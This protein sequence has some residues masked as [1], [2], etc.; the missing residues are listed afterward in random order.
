MRVLLVSTYESG[1]QPL[2]IAVPAAA[3]VDAGHEVKTADLALGPLDP[4]AIDWAEAAAFSVPMHTAMRLARTA[5]ALVRARRPDLPIAFYGLY[6]GSAPEEVPGPLGEVALVGEYVDLL[7]R[8]IDPATRPA[9]AVTSVE[10]GRS[11]APVPDR[12]GLRPLSEY[13]HLAANGGHRPAGYVEGSHGCRH[14]CRHCPIPAVY[15]GRYRV[16]PVETVLADVAQLVAAGARHIT[17]GDPD[18]LNG[19]AH[20]RRL[21]AAVS[22][23]YPDLTYDVTVKIEHILHHAGLW[24]ELA[25][26]GVIL[27]VSAFETT[28]DQ[29]L[30][31]L[32]KGHRAVE[33]V[34]AMEVVRSHGIELRPTW[35][36][37]TP[38]TRP[39]DLADILRFLVDH[40]LVES[41]DPIQLTLRLLIPPGSL[42]L[43]QPELLPYLGTYRPERLGYDWEYAVPEL[44]GLQHRMAATVERTAGAPA[45]SVLAEL[46]ALVAEVSGEDPVSIPAGALAGRP[47]LT[48]PW[49]C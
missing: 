47:R 11:S 19:P 21:L 43:N 12:S 15:D 18:F 28:N 40:D 42:L 16:V 32:A 22:S 34:Q 8:W 49:F 39:A 9:V 29:I 27:V 35:L 45:A 36:P 14:R 41:V 37:F 2:H 6:A 3:L 5:A 24:G 13:V 20:A 17:F 1:H 26:R 46:A 38:W 30:G 4:V 44:D 33:A 48:E 10:V 31:I 23:A 25:A 7:R